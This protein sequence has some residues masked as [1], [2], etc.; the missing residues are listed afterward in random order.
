M[1]DLD[2][3]TIDLFQDMLW[4]EIYFDPASSGVFSS[5]PTIPGVSLLPWVWEITG[6]RQS[7]PSPSLVLQFIYIVVIIIC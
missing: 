6:K 1:L 7:L 5:L 4:E 2:P 3:E